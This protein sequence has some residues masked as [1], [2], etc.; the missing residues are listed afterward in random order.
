MN[1]TQIKCFLTVAETL[2]FTK[3]AKQLFMTQ[4]GLSRYITSLERELNVLLFVRDKQRVRLTPAGALLAQELSDFENRMD[5]IINK[6][7]KIGEGYSGTL[8]IGTLCGQWFENVLMDTCNDFIS[9]NP[10][11]SLSFQQGSFRDLREWLISGKIDIAMTLEFDIRNLDDVL[12]ERYAEDVPIL[13]ISRHRKLA[14]KPDLTAEE[15]LKEPL[16]VISPDDSRAG[17]EMLMNAVRLTG[18]NKRDIRYAPNLAT[19]MMLIEAGQGVGVINHGSS[20]THNENIRVVELSADPSA[21]SCAAWL[22]SNFN[23]AISI[24]MDTLASHTRKT[25]S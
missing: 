14:D 20:I 16:I 6:V 13:G 8:T 19:L 12:F 11:I 3:A 23:P 18:A 4:P 5:E 21:S 25:I 24:F 7:Q 2:N 15:M 1:T 22:K 9:D 17:Y 10:N